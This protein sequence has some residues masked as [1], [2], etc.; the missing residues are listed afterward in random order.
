[1]INH[2]VLTISFTMRFYP[3]S[4][5]CVLFGLNH[6]LYLS[7]ILE[8]FRSN[9]TTNCLVIFFSLTG[10][11]G[12]MP[13][14]NTPQQIPKKS[15][16][17]NQII[18]YHMTPHTLGNSY[19]KSYV[20]RIAVKDPCGSKYI[21]QPL[22]LSTYAAKKSSLH[23]LETNNKTGQH[24]VVTLHATLGW[25]LP[26]TAARYSQGRVSQGNIHDN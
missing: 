23:N 14:C 25:R 13:T 24:K 15:L 10:I 9:W 22:C 2:S 11:N 20:K 5:M 6:Q 21:N 1:M 16:Q 18:S 26:S 3:T 17:I 19:A 7:F 12:E 8:V 4:Q